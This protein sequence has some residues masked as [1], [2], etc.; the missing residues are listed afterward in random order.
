MGSDKGFLPHPRASQ[1]RFV[2]HLTAV[3]APHCSELVLVARDDVQAAHYAQLHLASVRIVTD[4]LPDVGPLMGLYSGLRAIQSEHA[5]V[6]AVDLPLLQSDLLAF[7]LAQ[8]LDELIVVPIVADL[9]QVLLA[10]YPRRLLPTIEERLRE[11]RRDPRSLLQVAPVRFIEEAQLRI[12]D[13]QLRS[14]LNV[15]TP[16]ELAEVYKLEEQSGESSER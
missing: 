10:I 8:P 7:L 1:E 14:F 6:T 11:G 3:L 2:E 15:N 9:P 12:V 16:D 4:A 13:P 5:L